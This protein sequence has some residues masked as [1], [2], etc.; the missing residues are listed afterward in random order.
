[1]HTNGKLHVLLAE[2][3]PNDI[4]LLKHALDKNNSNADVKVA[5]DGEEV[6]EY[7]QGKGKYSDRLKFPFPDLLI[8]D[9]KMPRMTGLEVLNW[10]RDNPKCA[11]L[12]KVMLSGS[13]LDK[14]VEE[15]YRLGVNTY[16]QKPSTVTELR[17]L[18][19][20]LINYWALS[21]RPP[22]KNYC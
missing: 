9:L 7:L 1:M 17:D 2:D 21:Q 11:G 15:A 20:L 3:N 5:R 6:M 16:F 19:H 13:G 4:A 8:L 18:I 22:G 14:D 10:L 12:P